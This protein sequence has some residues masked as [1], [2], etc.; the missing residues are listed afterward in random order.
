MRRDRQHDLG[1]LAVILA[2]AE[3]PPQHGNI[4]QARHLVARA[5]L[6]IVDQARQ[7]LV[8]AILQLQHGRGLAR[9]DLVQG[10]AAPGDGGRA[11]VAHFER[12]ADTHLVIQ[13]DGRFGVHRQAHV[14]VAD[15][16]GS[17]AARARR[18]GGGH[19]GHPVADDELRLFAV[20]HA[21]A[22]IGQDIRVA[23][24][25]VDVGR[26]GQVAHAD[27]A[28]VQIIQVADGQPRAPRG[29]ERRQ[30][31]ARRP[32]HA[33]FQQAAA[34]DFEDF[35]LQYHFRLGHVL[36]RDQALGQA[37]RLGRV[38]HDDEV[39][40]FIGHH[41]ARLQNGLERVGHLFRIR[42]RQEEGFHQHFLVFLQLGRH[43]R[44]D[45]DGVRIHHLLLQLVRHQQEVDGRFDRAVLQEDRGFR[46]RL[47]VL[48]E[49]EIK[50]RAARNQFEHLF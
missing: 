40:L 37:D 14:Q 35:Q 46:V 27:A 30:G 47:D 4:A 20:A 13:V 45:Q 31:Q 8:F 28:L 23:V 44:V 5:A 10:R 2:A 18:N 7:H 16:F 21:D 11:Q 50:A 12:N 33:Q 41:V 25:L 29:G 19:H 36:Q 3:Q 48:V 24:L 42:V 32:G 43:V 6:F 38:A 39:E 34:L 17:E 22:R 26:H 1:L 15:G 9:A 49:D